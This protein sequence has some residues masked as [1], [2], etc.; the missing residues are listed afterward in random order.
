MACIVLMDGFEE[1]DSLARE[2]F[3]FTFD[4]LAYFKPPGWMLFLGQLP[5]TG[6]Q[7]IQKAQIFGPDTNPLKAD[8]LRDFRSFKKKTR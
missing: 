2:L 7:K 4:R 8:G 6:T 3:D 5:T 1:S